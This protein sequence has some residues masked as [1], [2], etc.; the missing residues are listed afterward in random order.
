MIAGRLKFTE[1]LALASAIRGSKIHRDGN[2]NPPLDKSGSRDR[3]DVLSA[4]VI[5]GGLAESMFDRPRRRGP[6]FFVA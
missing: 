4:A 6:R 1:S 2:A 5:A 3:I